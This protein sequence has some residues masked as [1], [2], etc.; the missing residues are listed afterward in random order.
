MDEK[1]KLIFSLLASAIEITAKDGD[2]KAASNIIKLAR[3]IAAT[4]DLHHE[5]SVI[6]MAVSCEV[7]KIASAIE[8]PE[9]TPSTHTEY[10]YVQSWFKHNYK[11][12]FPKFEMRKLKKSRYI[13]DFMLV[14]DEGCDMPVECKRV[15]NYRSLNQL[16][17]YMKHYNA[18]VGVA[19]AARLDVELPPNIIFIQREPDESQ[20]TI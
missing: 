13:P 5:I 6:A 17:D 12:Y 2:L 4:T 3:E 7:C 11:R 18:S 10:G 14:D 16:L 8:A 9:R 19:V 20:I 15:F 1:S